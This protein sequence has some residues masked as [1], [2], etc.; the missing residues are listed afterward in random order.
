MGRV[1][2]PIHG[3]N[4]G[5]KIVP[6]QPGLFLPQYV[7]YGLGSNSSRP[8]IRFS[9]LF[10][11]A[12]QEA[13]PENRRT[14]QPPACPSLP[15]CSDLSRTRPSRARKC[16]SLTGPARV[17]VRQAWAGAKKRASQAEQRNWDEER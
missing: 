15:P 13:D 8:D 3:F 7:G 10:A 11:V 12:C 4:A 1:T 2:G 9:G 5:Q 6:V 14:S 17:G 16:A